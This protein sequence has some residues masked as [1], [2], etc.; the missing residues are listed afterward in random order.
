MIILFEENGKL[1]RFD[2][3]C[4][5]PAGSKPD[6]SGVCYLERVSVGLKPLGKYE[7]FSVRDCLRAIAKIRNEILE[8][9]P[10]LDLAEFIELVRSMREAQLKKLIAD[11]ELEV[12]RWLELFKKVTGGVA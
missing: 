9:S 8:S 7:E 3:F 11:E 4:E 2:E 1:Y 5:N 6:E 12:D 10:Y